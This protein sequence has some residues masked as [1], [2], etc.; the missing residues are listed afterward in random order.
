MNCAYKEL[1][2]VDGM[3]YSLKNIDY[4]E[5]YFWQTAFTF[6]FLCLKLKKKFLK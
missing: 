6:F 1:R 4:Y 3:Y 2:L 5:Y